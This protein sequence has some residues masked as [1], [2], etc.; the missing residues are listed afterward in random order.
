VFPVSRD[1][2][3]EEE[4]A[5]TQLHSRTGDEYYTYSNVPWKLHMRKEVGYKPVFN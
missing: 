1:L 2:P 4:T 5:Q 3:V